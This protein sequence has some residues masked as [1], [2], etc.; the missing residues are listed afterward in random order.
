MKRVV[1]VNF[2]A[3]LA[4][5]LLSSCHCTQKIVGGVDKFNFTVPVNGVDRDFIVDLPLDY[6]CTIDYPVVVAIHGKGQLNERA[7]DVWGW[8][9][10]GES[11][12]FITVYPQSMTYTFGPTQE[13]IT[14]WDDG[15]LSD[16]GNPLDLNPANQTI[17]DDVAFIRAMVAYVKLS[18]ST[19]PNKFYVT[20]FS[21]GGGLTWRLS[22]ET[23][24]IFK[25]FAPFA[26][27]LNLT[28]VNP[29]VHRSVYFAG[30]DS[31]PFITNLNGGQPLDLDVTD[32][33]T[34]FQPFHD[35]ELDALELQDISSVVNV[36][37]DQ[38]ILEWTQPDDP[39][40]TH[41]YKLLLL[42]DTEH[43]YPSEL[44]SFRNPNLHHV[45]DIYWAFFES[46]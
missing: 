25:G 31:D 16:P 14:R 30:G 1:I 28:G 5:F 46:L 8:K 9:E 23:G 40:N 13:L 36:N 2:A 42:S 20:G 4:I 33:I 44:N 41:F 17:E 15:Q 32:I 21:N 29:N 26:G 18:Y 43:V 38:V 34:F 11:E 35:I 45:A 6:D 24:D 37:N 19:D 22:M 10:K 39:T 27:L 12:Q 3:V 7:W